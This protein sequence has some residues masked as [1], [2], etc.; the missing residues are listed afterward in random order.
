MYARTNE[1]SDGAHASA[2]SRRESAHLHPRPL[3]TLAALVDALDAE[4]RLADL[5]DRTARQR[6]SAVATALVQGASTL[7]D[8]GAAE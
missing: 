7:E 3:T 1:E 2:S 4:V 8:K 6:A 5:G